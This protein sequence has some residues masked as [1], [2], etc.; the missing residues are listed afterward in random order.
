M[1]AKMVREKVEREN[2]PYATGYS[3][4]DARDLIN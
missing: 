3:Y 4:T 2:I 1:Q